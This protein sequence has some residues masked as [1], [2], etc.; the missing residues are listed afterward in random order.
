[1]SRRLNKQGEREHGDCSSNP[2]VSQEIARELVFARVPRKCCK[3]VYANAAVVQR[4]QHE[5]VID[6]IASLVA[7]RQVVAR[8]VASAVLLDQ[9]ISDLKA[10]L[11]KCQNALSYGDG[12]SGE[13]EVE[14]SLAPPLA[15]PPMTDGI[16]LSN[17]YDELSLPDNL[18]AGVFANTATVRF[19]VGEF[20][21]D[22]IAAFY[23]QPVLVKRVYMATCRVPA[24][25]DVL[26]SARTIASRA[27]HSTPACAAGTEIGEE[28]LPPGYRPC[29]MATTRERSEVDR[30]RR[31]PLWTWRR[32]VPSSILPPVLARRHAIP[33]VSGGV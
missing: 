20:L 25:L 28:I 31:E 11:E 14:V 27:R 4:A 3:G 15:E 12:A 1:M 9:L 19:G 29:G 22:F 16:Q 21:I 6:F 2:T 5:F 23:P 13:S 26:V 24:L 30:Q 18:F 32:G 8:V 33:S 7:P 17:L 10:N